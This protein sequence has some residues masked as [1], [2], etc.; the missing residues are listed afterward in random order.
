MDK[1]LTERQKAMRQCAFDYLHFLT[2]QE[3]MVER[4]VDRRLT[5]MQP[6]I[7]RLI[8]EQVDRR[9]QQIAKNRKV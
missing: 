8:E 3:M 4:L 1:Q 7:E 5:E 6:K 9:L 2:D